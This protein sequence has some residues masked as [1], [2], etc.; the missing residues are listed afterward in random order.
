MYIWCR[1][2]LQY[3]YLFASSKR[4]LYC[5]FVCEGMEK[6]LELT[7]SLAEWSHHFTA[8]WYYVSL[9]QLSSRRLVMNPVMESTNLCV[10]PTNAFRGCIW[11]LKW[12]AVSLKEILLHKPEDRGLDSRGG[13]MEFFNT[14]LFWLRYGSGVDLDPDWDVYENMSCGIAAAGA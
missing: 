14:L 2:G 4:V 12:L 13:P 9:R 8:K 5:C 7:A 1:I 11:L 3:L 10:L 6:R